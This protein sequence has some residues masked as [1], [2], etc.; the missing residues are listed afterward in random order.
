MPSSSHNIWNKH[1]GVCASFTRQFLIAEEASKISGGEAPAKPNLLPG[2][3]CS[4]IAADVF[5]QVFYYYYYSL[6][7]KTVRSGCVFFPPSFI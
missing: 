7:Q 5:I 2:C 3:L 6:S 1:V 4:L